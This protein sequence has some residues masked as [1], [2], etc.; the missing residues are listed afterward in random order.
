ME[1]F[2]RKWTKEE[3]DFLRENYAT[4][5]TYQLAEIW[6]E[7]FNVERTALAIRSRAKKVCK[8]FK[9]QRAKY[10][11]VKCLNCGKE[12]K[13]NAR[14]ILINIRFCSHKCHGEYKLKSY[15]NKI[16]PSASQYNTVYKR[17]KNYIESSFYNYARNQN[18]SY[19][20]IIDHF[21]K[22]QL[23][24]YVAISSRIGK[25]LRLKKF[26]LYAK[27]HVLRNENYQKRAIKAKMQEF[28]TENIDLPIIAEKRFGCI[29]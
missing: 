27:M 22:Y 17:D 19:D 4:K 28:I 15:E 6:I 11:I 18:V 12:F 2:M 23:K 16:K 29:S 8:G 10:D 20:D 1:W 24:Y 5:N 9:L 21:Y 13:R 7:K 14:G 26:M 3:D 25:P